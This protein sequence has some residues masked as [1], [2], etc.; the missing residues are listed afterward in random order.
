ML[1]NLYERTQF[2][3]RYG[4]IKGLQKNMYFVTHKF[5]EDKV[6]DSTSKLNQFEADY[7]INLA[8]YL[9]GHGYYESQITL[10]TT[11]L[12]NLRLCTFVKC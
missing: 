1:S 8:K 2:L 7:L 6:D 11:Y 9:I 3:C 4:N 5:T 12:G 10:L